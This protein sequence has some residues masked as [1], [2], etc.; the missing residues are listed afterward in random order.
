MAAPKVDLTA[1]GSG[2]YRVFVNGGQISRHIAE[3]EA[4]EVATEQALINKNAQIY[5]D[6]DYEVDVAVRIDIG[7]PAPPGGETFVA[8]NAERIICS[9]ITPGVTGGSGGSNKDGPATLPTVVPSRTAPTFSGSIINVDSAHAGNLQAAINAAS[10]GDILELTAQTVYTGNFVIDKSLEVRTTDHAVIPSDQFR[11]KTSDLWL[12][13]LRTASTDR[14]LKIAPGVDGVNLKGLYFDVATTQTTNMGALIDYQGGSVTTVAQLPKNIWMDHCVTR[15]H[16]GVNC[17]RAVA[18]NGFHIAFV[19]CDLS[20]TGHAAQPSGQD[21]QSLWS[22]NGGIEVLVYNTH[23]RAAGEGIILGGAANQNAQMNPRDWTIQKTL[24]DRDPAWFTAAGQGDPLVLKNLFESKNSSQTL[25]EDC[26]FKNYWVE[27]GQSYAVNLKSANQGSNQAWQG[28][29]DLTIRDCRFIDCPT[30]VSFAGIGTS[31]PVDPFRLNNISVR[32]CD[33]QA[34][35]TDSQFFGRGNL[36]RA[37][38]FLNRPSNIEINN[39]SI[40]GPFDASFGCIDF[41]FGQGVPSTLMDSLT[42]KNSMF[43]RQIRGRAVSVEGTSVLDAYVTTH[44][45]Q[46]NTFIGR[47]EALYPT[48]GVGNNGNNIAP[49]EAAVGFTNPSANLE[50]WTLLAGSAAKGTGTAGTDPG[51]DI[52]V[53]NAAVAGVETGIL[54]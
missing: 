46:G 5:Y 28:T 51:A 4:I 3:R 34:S 16:F 32:N 11:A 38:V 54:T 6:H 7:F 29:S 33:A 9:V 25:I 43:Q 8:P 45:V 41:D 15:A 13:R 31:G 36:A 35:G 52:A 39:V 20:D 47:D 50:D 49:N 26:T 17:Q 53:I 1:R 44:D 37:F 42:I 10:A 14:V 22:G 18:A 19:A 48:A 2:Y 24:F 40:M 21:T 30:L 23:I 27:D 12:A